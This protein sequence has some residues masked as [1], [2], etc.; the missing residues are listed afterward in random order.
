MS[1]GH[2]QD[3]RS[4]CK[5]PS[6]GIGVVHAQAHGR[7][8]RA[9]PCGALS[10]PCKICIKTRYFLR[11]K[12]YSYE[13]ITICIYMYVYMYVY[14]YTDKL[15]ASISKNCFWG[16]VPANS[17]PHQQRMLWSLK[18]SL[19]YRGLAMMLYGNC[20]KYRVLEGVVEDFEGP[21]PHDSFI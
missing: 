19:T 12:L 10:K 14:V 1:P 7:G 4:C 15:R 17:I 16:K 11:S 21:D 2:V 13:N 8:S 3:S 5:I 20:L 6:S 18:C 9:A